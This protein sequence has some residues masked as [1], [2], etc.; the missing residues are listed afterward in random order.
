MVNN[1]PS[2]SLNTF[3]IY[4]DSEDDDHG[5]EGPK[6]KRTP[7]ERRISSKHSSNR[8]LSSPNNFVS[9]TDRSQE[10]R[11]KEEFH[12]SIQVTDHSV[13][14]TILSQKLTG[15]KNPERKK[16]FIKAFK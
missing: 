10:P 11:E 8:S 2:I 16:N 9:E 15:V 3:D 1:S 5:D 4:D 6:I 13:A 7:R 12:Q 14:P